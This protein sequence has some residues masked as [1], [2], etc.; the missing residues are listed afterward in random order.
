MTAMLIIM[1]KVTA[2]PL[3]ALLLLL[4][5]LQQEVQAL[6]TGAPNCPFDE[7]APGRDSEFAPHMPTTGFTENTLAGGG[8]NIN[9]GGQELVDGVTELMAETAYE[10]V[11]SHDD[12]AAIRGVLIRVSGG[13]ASLDTSSFVSIPADETH[14]QISQPCTGS[15]VSFRLNCC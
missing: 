2:A 11:V 8:F 14:L 4:L 15:G 13:D 1:K 7:S 12:T 9:I 10:L 5:L 6:S 3:F